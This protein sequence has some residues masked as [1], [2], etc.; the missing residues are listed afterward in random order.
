MNAAKPPL[1][2]CPQVVP[3][4]L[5]PAKLV[6][7]VAPPLEQNLGTFVPSAWLLGEPAARFFWPKGPKQKHPTSVDS[8][9]KMNPPPS[10]LPP[11]HPSS[12][13]PTPR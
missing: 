7:V 5:S 12:S 6:V 13:I 4:E 10:P 9:C 3:Q 11:P 1:P 2:H 8:S